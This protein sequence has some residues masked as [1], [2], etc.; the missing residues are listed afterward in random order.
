MDKQEA[1]D[2]AVVAA[3]L[4]EGI[5]RQSD[6]MELAYS[7]TILADTWASIASAMPEEKKW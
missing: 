1:I 5:L 6:D 2:K 3:T 7:W 4:A